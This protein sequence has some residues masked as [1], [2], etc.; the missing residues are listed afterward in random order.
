MSAPVLEARKVTM[1]FGGLKALSEFELVI[2][3]RELVGLIGPNGAGK[4]TLFNCISG[5]YRPSAG[6]IAFDGRDM[7]GAPRHRMAGMGIGRTFQNLA[8]FRTLTVRDNVLAGAHSRGVAGFAA[9]A[10]RSAAAR[11]SMPASRSSA[12]MSLPRKPLAPAR[13]ARRGWSRSQT[14]RGPCRHPTN[15]RASRAPRWCG[16][17][18]RRA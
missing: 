14:R 9:S 11:R 5:I 6:R 1:Q 15:C 16:S 10:F 7:T 13:R 12:A 2:Q 17:A 3:P 4:T 18:R 8:L